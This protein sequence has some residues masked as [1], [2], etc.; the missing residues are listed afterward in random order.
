[1]VIGGGPDPKLLSWGN[2]GGRKEGDLSGIGAKFGAAGPSP[3]GKG[4]KTSAV[5]K[6]PPSWG[7]PGGGG[8]FSES[9]PIEPLSESWGAPG[10]GGGFSESG[11]STGSLGPEIVSL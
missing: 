7:G 2:G 6:A 11:P 5:I 3:G 10:G 1:M 8:G 9:G 4:G